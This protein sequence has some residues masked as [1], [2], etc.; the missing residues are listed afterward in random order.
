MERQRH[1][2]DRRAFLIHPTE[3]GRAAKA[4]AVRILDRQQDL[5]MAGL[6]RAER[7]QLAALL[8]KLHESLTN[9]AS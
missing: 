8:K 1:P 3:T 5:F 9:P 2:R 6:T 7:E 4:R